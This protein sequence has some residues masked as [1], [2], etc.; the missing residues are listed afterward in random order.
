MALFST[1]WGRVSSIGAYL[2]ADVLAVENVSDPIHAERMARYRRNIEYYLGSQYDDVNAPLFTGQSFNAWARARVNYTGVIPQTVD[3]KADWL[4]GEPPQVQFVF[5]EKLATDTRPAEEATAVPEKVL[6]ERFRDIR[7]ANDLDFWEWMSAVIGQICGDF[8]W[9]VF[10]E[11]ETGDVQVE[12][13]DPLIVFPNYSPN[14][15][16]KVLPALQTRFMRDQVLVVRDWRLERKRD[17][18]MGQRT[19]AE[20]EAN[21]LPDKYLKGD[22]T[23]L[24]CMVRQFENGQMISAVDLGITQL[25]WVHGVNMRFGRVRYGIDEVSMLV[26]KVEKYNDLMRYAERTARVNANAKLGVFGARPGKLK[27]DADDVIYFPEG[28]SSQ[29]ISLPSDTGMLTFVKDELKDTMY[30]DAGVPR[31][32]LGEGDMGSNIPALSL[33]LKFQRLVQ[34]T[35]RHRVTYGTAMRRRDQLILSL[36]EEFGSGSAWSAKDFQLEYVWYDAMPRSRAAAI[37]DGATAAPGK[38]LVS[39][40]TIQSWIPGADPKEESG[41]LEKETQAAQAGQMAANPLDALF[42]GLGIES[43][44]AAPGETGKV[45]GQIEPPRR[46]AQDQFALAE[47]PNGKQTA[48]PTS[49]RPPVR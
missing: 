9:Y 16:I 11:P 17:K 7:E 48:L 39:L 27:G 34:V 29:V 19:L 45:G 30:K 31:E 3:T 36:D 26:P 38:Q 21:P 12:L 49:S 33:E 24:T 20:L 25:P 32:A 42:A 46:G 40:E 43:P 6:K 41:R 14:L 8:F 23:G 44:S 1:I 22:L 4:Y 2:N 5:A 37:V 10:V 35:R 18:N 15:T 28:A 13:V 47:S